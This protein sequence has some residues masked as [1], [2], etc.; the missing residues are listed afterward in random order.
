MNGPQI[1]TSKGVALITGTWAIQGTADFDGDG[2]GDI[3][4]RND[5]GA[6]AVWEMNGAN[7]AGAQNISPL[8]TDWTLGVHHYDFV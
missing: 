5:N 6:V 7:I 1:K 2:K 8:G 3:L 4:W